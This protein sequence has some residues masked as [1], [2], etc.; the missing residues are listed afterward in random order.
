[1]TTNV[2]ESGKNEI[3]KLRQLNIRQ[4]EREIAINGNYENWYAELEEFRNSLR[5][6]Y[7]YSIGGGGRGRKEKPDT[8]CVR[9]QCLRV[10]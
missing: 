3:E 5:K 7:K 1:M 2:R 8:I 4:L 10:R 9:N 6:F